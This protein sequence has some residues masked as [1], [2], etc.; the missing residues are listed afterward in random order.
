MLYITALF[1]L[2]QEH[3]QILFALLP[4]PQTTRHRCP[5]MQNSQPARLNSLTSAPSH[6]RSA[7]LPASPSPSQTALLCLP[8]PGSSADPSQPAGDQP[9]L[10][11]WSQR[12]QVKG[13]SQ[14]L[15]PSV[16]P[17]AKSLLWDH[18]HL[19]LLQPQRKGADDACFGKKVPSPQIQHSSGLRN[20]AENRLTLGWWSPRAPPEVGKCGTRR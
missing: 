3:V 6:R 2:H 17:T 16:G 7:R 13:S 5:E 8:Q 1:F 9:R 18:P 10:W 12:G 19:T 14:G 20:S 4:R 15:L 11:A